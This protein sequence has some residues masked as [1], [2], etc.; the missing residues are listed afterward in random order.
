MTQTGAEVGPGWL[1]EA[2]QAPGVWRQS[3]RSRQLPD[4][5]L[6]AAGRRPGSISLRCIRT[7]RIA[8]LAGG[9]VG[10]LIV[11]YRTRNPVGWLL[12]ANAAGH[13]LRTLAADYAA[14]TF[15]PGHGW[16]P[17]GTVAAWL[18]TPVLVAAGP[19][20]AFAFLR[21]P[22]GALLSS[23]WRAAEIALA[24]ALAAAL[25]AVCVLSWPL[26]GRVLLDGAVLPPTPHGRALAAASNAGQ[27][28][29]GV[30][31]ILAAMSL[32]MRYRRANGLVRQQLKWISLGAV[33]FV[34]LLIA[35][36]LVGGVPGGILAIVSPLPLL[37]AVVV[38]I[39]RYRLYDIDRIISRTVAYTTLTVALAAAFFV[40]A[41]LVAAMFGLAGDGSPA[42]TAAAAV[43]VT[44]LFQP[45]RTRLQDLCDRK[46][47]RRSYEATRMVGAYLDSL[48]QKEPENGALAATLR[49]A[50]AD[51][52]V[53]IAFW[54]GEDAYVDEEG[55]PVELPYD[56]ARL[57]YRIDRAG[58]HLGI[59]LAG[60]VPPDPESRGC[61]RQS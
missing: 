3:R 15:A 31:L 24:T 51:P 27:A 16:L 12:V 40:V 43:A 10:A 57:V 38:A 21:F 60:A 25:V 5:L 28:I 20:L 23:R 17:G 9:S 6:V 44:A 45:V 53:G 11:Q 33:P 54:V 1:G 39:R 14:F 7:R 13:G 58:E 42:A 48:R 36:R 8:G 35:A 18:A 32:V 49:A 46:F 29:A 52:S 26:R 59:L 56:A 4:L 55:S 47:R 22:D 50:L 19:L 61:S 30:A 37:A 34:V 2:P 41:T